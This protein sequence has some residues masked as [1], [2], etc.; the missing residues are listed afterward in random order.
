M[1]R[2]VTQERAIGATGSLDI[3]QFSAP[4]LTVVVPIYNEEDSIP[5]L[6]RRLTD[7]LEKLDVS[8]EIITVDDGSRDRSFALLDELAAHD[9][10]L[11]VVRFRRN[12]GQ[13]AAFSAG[14]CLAPPP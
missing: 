5:Q 12:F 9:H 7:E 1:D 2:L 13:T 14:C 8:Y 3:E 11:R 6:Y 10:R 4:Y